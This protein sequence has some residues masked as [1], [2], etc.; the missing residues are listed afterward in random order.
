MIFHLLTAPSGFPL[1]IT[2]SVVN[3]SS[4]QL[5]WSP[6]PAS[7][8]NGVIRSYQIHITELDTTSFFLLSANLTS[9][10]IA[11][12]HPFYSYNFSVAAVT[13]GIG[14]F[15]AP[16][17]VTTLEDGKTILKMYWL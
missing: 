3:S 15:S 5:S 14:P 11:T 9:S 17:T 16:H 12:L 2:V 8:H 1:D 13:I 6:P 4:V 7:Q 10:V